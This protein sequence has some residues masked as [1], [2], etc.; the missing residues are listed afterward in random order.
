MEKSEDQEK[1][2]DDFIIWTLNEETLTLENSG[3]VYFSRK[4]APG[5]VRCNE[6]KIDRMKKI[7]ESKIK[8]LEDQN[9]LIKDYF[10]LK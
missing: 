8:V 2:L 7:I 1:W 5:W 9:K 3:D 4:E 6:R 10:D